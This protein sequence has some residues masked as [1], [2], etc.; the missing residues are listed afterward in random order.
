[1][2]N[3]LRNSERGQATVELALTIFIFLAFILV[4][5]DMVRI[6]YHWVSLQYAV[7]EGARFASLGSTTG[8]LD[9]SASIEAKIVEV[10]ADLGVQDVSVTFQD[11]T[12]GGSAGTPLSFLKVQAMTPVTL[13]P[14]SGLLLKI[15][16]NYS[17]IYD[18]FAETYIRNEAFS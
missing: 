15:S 8:E 14:L 18:V 10:A 1:M 16:G 11:D 13:N 4:L 3:N 7:N 2:R 17:G 12:G 5:A 9:R 6:C